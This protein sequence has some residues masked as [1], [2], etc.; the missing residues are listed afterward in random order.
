MYL[1]KG[2]VSDFLGL[3]LNIFSF[4]PLL[5]LLASCALP[6]LALPG[7]LHTLTSLLNRLRLSQREG[8]SQCHTVCWCQVV[9]SL[10]AYE[11]V[12]MCVCVCAWEREGESERERESLSSVYV[13]T[14]M[15]SPPFPLGLV[16]FSHRMTV[17][18]VISQLETFFLLPHDLLCLT[19]GYKKFTF[20]L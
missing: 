10:C 6:V 9:L 18:V 20:S 8:G 1:C 11:R 16:I 3:Y 15:A 2:F 13:S 7:K 5:L 17:C 14:C 12:C 4:F 19:G